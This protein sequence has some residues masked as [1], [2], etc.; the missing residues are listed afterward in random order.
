MRRVGSPCLVRPNQRQG[1]GHLVSRYLA[2]FDDSGVTE[3][4][5]LLVP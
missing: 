5:R 4:L 1:L 2:R 3:E